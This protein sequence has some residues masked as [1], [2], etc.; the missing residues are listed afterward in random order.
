MR[1]MRPLAL[2]AVTWTTV[3]AAVAS[4]LWLAAVESDQG[5]ATR[6][7]TLRPQRTPSA[8]TSDGSGADVLASR[9]PDSRAATPQVTLR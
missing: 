5:T 6:H 4:A 3:A 1:K 7:T 8:W 2:K 9:L